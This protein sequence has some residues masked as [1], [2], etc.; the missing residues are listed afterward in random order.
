MLVA[1]GDAEKEDEQME[2]ME[3]GTSDHSSSRS[4][5]ESDHFDLDDL[6]VA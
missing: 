5:L 4:R 6:E 3:E 2:E 1:M